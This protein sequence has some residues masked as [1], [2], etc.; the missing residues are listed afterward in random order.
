MHNMTLS[1]RDIGRCRKAHCTHT[2]YTHT[3]ICTRTCTYTHTYTHIPHTFPSHTH[4]P[5]LLP[6]P[7][8]TEHA[9]ED[10]LPACQNTL[11]NLQLDYLDL[12][13]IHW[14][15]SLKKG[16]VLRQLK[17]EEKLGYDPTRMT[18]CWEVSGWKLVHSSSI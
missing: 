2:T 3:Y 15:I 7:S 14:P 4:T 11:K 1:L 18:H 8:N 16:S 17:D 6:H 13:L 5:S 10:V 12:Y 9:K